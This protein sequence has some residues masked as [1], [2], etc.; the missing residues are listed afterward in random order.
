[1]RRVRKVTP[2]VRTRT[3]ALVAQAIAARPGKPGVVVVVKARSGVIA[4]SLS[5]IR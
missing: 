3:A 5:G 1:M 4:R 2:A